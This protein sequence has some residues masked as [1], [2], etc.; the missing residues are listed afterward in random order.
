M[1]PPEPMPTHRAALGSEAACLSTIR[2]ALLKSQR[3]VD[4]ADDCGA[5]RGRT[6]LVSS[7]ALVEGVHFDRRW[8]N[9]YQI[10]AQAAV[11]NLSDMAA[12]G[13][14]PVW[15]TWSLI[16]PDDVSQANLKALTAGFGGCCAQYGAAVI[17]GNLTRARGP[18]TIAVTVGGACM[19]RRPLRRDGARV[20]DSVF[21]SGP[22]GDAALGW[23][24]PARFRSLRHGWRP[25]LSHARL[26]ACSGRATAGLDISDGL[27]LDASRLASASGL[28]INVQQDAIPTS[29]EYAAVS[30]DKTLAMTG[31]E[32]YVLLFTA[33]DAPWPWAHRIGNCEAGEGLHLDG[34]Q[35]EGPL[36]FD[37]FGPTTATPTSSSDSR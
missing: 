23:R 11:A 22:V 18:L 12:S 35:V 24:W 36:G 28:R 30:S 17:G 29:P 5:P 37:H 19:G 4:F 6:D 27:L 7:D 31:G 20:G 16:L 13:A 8:D 3:V 14:A 9:F 25:H 10:G 32:D 2:R 26:L 34:V 33:P 21:V 1:E 15:L